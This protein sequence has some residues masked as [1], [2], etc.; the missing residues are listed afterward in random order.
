M[1]ETQI[2]SAK[3]WQR[4]IIFWATTLIFYN[5]LDFVG[6]DIGIGPT[7]SP[8][9]V[10]E[11]LLMGQWDLIGRR[12]PLHH[13]FVEENIIVIIIVVRVVALSSSVVVVIIIG[14]T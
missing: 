2:K 5:S 7:Q 8:L 3:Q 6:S 12:H 10:L 1:L 13:G 9:H 11:L 14:V 4:H